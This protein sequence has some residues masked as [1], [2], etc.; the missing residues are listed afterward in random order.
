MEKDNF[1][2][3]LEIAEAKIE[4]ARKSGAR[5][6]NLSLLGLTE[7][8]ASITQLS[9]VQELIL[10][11]NE[12]TALP[13]PLG[14]L[15]QLTN[16]NLSSN[17][18]A[19][20]PAALGQFT[21]LQRL[22]LAGNNLTDLP[23]VLSHLTQ[24]RILH[25]D[26]NNL[27]TFPETLGQLTQLEELHINENQLT[28]LPEFLGQLA[29]LQRLNLSGNQ[30]TA[31]PETLGQLAQLQR[32]SLRN[33]RLITLPETLG[34][35]TKLTYLDLENNQLT[36][37][38]EALGQLTQLEELDLSNNRLTALPEALS[39]LTQLRTLELS[40]NQLPILPESLRNLKSLKGLY[41]HD[42]PKLGIP[43]EILGPTWGD[44]DEKNKPANPA[45]ILDYYFR[46][47]GGKRPLNEA[48]LIL[49]GRGEVGKTCLVNRLVKNIFEPTDKT[50][51]IAISDWQVN[52]GQDQ[53]RMN[54]WDFG[55][56]EIMH[57]THQFF[58]TDRSLYLLVLN[59]REGGEDLD[60]E[61]WL[62][63]IASFGGDSPVIIVQNKIDQHSFDLNYR[64]LQAKYPQIRGYV[65]TDC[66]TPT[67]FAELESRIK[68]T[69]GEMTNVRAS[70]P[71]AWFAIKD[72]LA[73]MKVNYL[74]FDQFRATCARLGEGDSKSQ[75][76]LAGFLHCLGVALNYKD[77]PR[78]RDTSVL[79]PR[80]VTEGIYRLLNAS[81]L[82]K[83]QG[84]L[85]L[86]DLSRFLLSEEYPPEKHE[87][88]LELMRKFHL[89]FA[90]PDN[91]H[92][93]LVPELL[94]KEE[95]DL[96]KEFAPE[97]CLNFE[98]HYD[99]LPEG[100]L[101]QF[102]VRSHIHS[103][104]QP[105]WRTGVVL[106][107]ENCRAM[108]KAE[109]GTRRVVVRVRDDG[110]ESRRRLLAVIRM[111][112]ERI[113]AGIPRLEVKTK[114]PLPK[115]PEVVIDYDKL[116]SF[117]RRGIKDFPEVVGDDV[118]IVSV[119]ELLSGVDLPNV[120]KT[121]KTKEETMKAPKLF[122]SYSHKD[123]TL[124]DKLETHLKLL[125]REGKI[126]D[127]HDR[128]ITAGTEWAKQIDDHL[129]QADIILLLVSADFIASDYCYDL[130]MKRAM[131]RHEKKEAVV[132]PVILRDCDWHC[133]P[134]SKLQALPK[135]G[136]PVKKWEDR[137]TAWTDVAKGIRR[138]A[139]ELDSRPMP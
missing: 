11:G 60:A 86:H 110:S 91:Q 98:Y 61:Y 42:N 132:I 2:S 59:G 33:N 17:Q 124:R 68:Q 48:K 40:N 87:F 37:V 8:P 90:F 112:F 12:L 111:D 83:Q 92:R 46:L 25:L 28:M 31:L 63:L 80:W 135:D 105:R 21:Q 101:P 35:L 116:V 76:E 41:L 103:Q 130:E 117:E 104:G 10:F 106:R 102:I 67:G 99:I 74:S 50:E 55:G 97:Q 43:P 95:P 89:C 70:F 19:V 75:E 85:I 9:Q 109:A 134:F 5:E 64:G 84:E 96:K 32:L 58:L 100:L 123:E 66:R 14:Q 73:G 13:E 81:A 71:K 133:A 6:L 136:R 27:T 129:N 53:V 29:Q 69:L 107:W 72:E 4:L 34:H 114:V 45:S 128:R 118:I 7:L 115:H 47:R 108:V 36:A 38:P 120:R 65:K 49:V 126:S 119:V 15:V 113:H 39:Q 121:T 77:D 56:Q 139:E 82:A 125:K 88:L 54:I 138:V 20:L 1:I 57:A 44:A 51:G 79:K 78:L 16:L 94:G 127:W 137:D 23:E 93:Y 18:L 131:E 26:G 24:L 30:L 122:Y 62:K 22:D 3:P 52:V